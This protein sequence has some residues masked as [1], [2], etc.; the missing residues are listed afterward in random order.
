MIFSFFQ[1][2][3][4][5]LDEETK[6][7]LQ[8]PRQAVPYAIIQLRQ[9]HRTIYR[10]LTTVREKILA[11][12]RNK[13]TRNGDK[14]YKTIVNRRKDDAHPLVPKRERSRRSSDCSDSS[15]DAC[16][17]SH[18]SNKHSKMSKIK[19][20]R[21]RSTSST[22]RSSNKDHEKLTTGDVGSDQSLIQTK[23]LKIEEEIKLKQSKLTELRHRT[24]EKSIEEGEYKQV[25]KLEKNTN[26]ISTED[27][28][29]IL[30]TTNLDNHLDLKITSVYSTSDID[31]F[32]KKEHSSTTKYR[33][34]R[35]GAST[36][37]LDEPGDQQSEQESRLSDSLNCNGNSILD[38]HISVVKENMKKLSDVKDSGDTLIIKGTQE[39]ILHEEIKG[40]END[41]VL[42][43]EESEAHVENLATKDNKIVSGH[44]LAVD[45]D[46]VKMLPI[47]SERSDNDKDI[48]EQIPTDS[49]TVDI[50]KLFREA[51]YKMDPSDLYELLTEK[52]ADSADDVPEDLER[53]DEQTA[54]CV[55]DVKHEHCND[56]MVLDLSCKNRTVDVIDSAVVH[57]NV[58]RRNKVGII[59]NVSPDG[60]VYTKQDEN[61]K[62]YVEE[63]HNHLYIHSLQ[64]G[65]IKD[66][67]CTRTE[68]PRFIAM[69]NLDILASVASERKPA[70]SMV[71]SEIVNVNT[72]TKV[73]IQTDNQGSSIQSPST[74]NQKDT[75]KSVTTIVAN[76]LK[77]KESLLLLTGLGVREKDNIT[78]TSNSLDKTVL[79]V[80]VKKEQ[81]CILGEEKVYPNLKGISSP[82]NHPN[83][84]AAKHIRHETVNPCKSHTT[85]V[86][87]KTDDNSPVVQNEPIEKGLSITNKSRRQSKT[88]TVSSKQV[89]RNTKYTLMQ[90]AQI[91]PVLASTKRKTANSVDAAFSATEQFNLKKN[92]NAYNAPKPK[93]A[94]KQKGKASNVDKV[95]AN[96]LK[97][98]S[99]HSK[100]KVLKSGKVCTTSPETAQ[101]CRESLFEKFATC[102]KEENDCS[103]NKAT[104]C[105]QEQP[106]ANQ[107]VLNNGHD[108]VKMESEQTETGSQSPPASTS[109]HTDVVPNNTDNKASKPCGNETHALD[110]PVV[111]T[112]NRRVTEDMKRSDLNLNTMSVVVKIE[113][114]SPHD[115]HTYDASIPLVTK[116]AYSDVHKSRKS[117]EQTMSVSDIL[118]SKTKERN[119]THTVT[120]P[121][122]VVVKKEPLSPTTCSSSFFSAPSSEMV[123]DTDKRIEQVGQNQIESSSNVVSDETKIESKQITSEI[124]K[125]LKDLEQV[126]EEFSQR[127]RR[128]SESVVPNEH[129]V[130]QTKCSTETVNEHEIKQENI[131]D[132]EN[133]S[134]VV[135]TE[136]QIQSKREDISTNSKS[137]TKEYNQRKSFDEIVLSGI[138]PIEVITGNI[139]TRKAT[140]ANKVSQAITLT[141]HPT[142]N[143]QNK[144]PSNKDKSNNGQQCKRSNMY[145]GM[146]CAKVKPKLITSSGNMLKNNEDDTVIRTT[147]VLNEALHESKPSATGVVKRIKKEPI[148]EDEYF[149]IARSSLFEPLNVK[150]KKKSHKKCLDTVKLQHDD[151]YLEGKVSESTKCSGLS[152]YQDATKVCE[153]SY[154]NNT[155]RKTKIK[156]RQD[157]KTSASSYPCETTKGHS[158]SSKS[159]DN[160]RRKRSSESDKE[161]HDIRRKDTNTKYNHMS[162]SRSTETNRPSIDESPPRDFS[163][164]DKHVFVRK[165]YKYPGYSSQISNKY[166]AV[167]N[168]SWNF[169]NTGLPK[170]STNSFWSPY[171]AKERHTKRYDFAVSNRPHYSRENSYQSNKGIYTSN[172]YKLSTTNKKDTDYESHN[173]SMSNSIRTS[174]NNSYKS[175]SFS[176]ISIKRE[177]SDSLD[178]RPPSDFKRTRSNS[179]DRGKWFNDTRH[180]SD[181]R[182]RTNV[183]Q[184]EHKRQKSDSRDRENV[185]QSERKRQRSDSR[186]RENVRQSERKRQRS[187][188][189]DRKNVRHFDRKRQ[190]SDSRDHDSRFKFKR[191]NSRST[192]RE[193]S[194]SSGYKRRSPQSKSHVGLQQDVGNRFDLNRSYSSEHRDSHSLSDMSNRG[195]YSNTSSSREPDESEI[196]NTLSKAMS[197]LLKKI[198]FD[199][200]VQDDSKEGRMA[201]MVL[202]MVKARVN[203][204]QG[205]DQTARQ[206]YR[207]S[208]SSFERQT[209]YDNTNNIQRS[210]TTPQT[211]RYST[212]NLS[213]SRYSNRMS[214][215]NVNRSTLNSNRPTI[216]NSILRTKYN[217]IYKPSSF[218]TQRRG[219]GSNRPWSRGRF[220]NRNIS[221]RNTNIR[222]ISRG[223]SRYSVRESRPERETEPSST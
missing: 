41:R 115:N 118:H 132:H 168:R 219:I 2:Y 124:D 14:G 18:K 159:N 88:D 154:D 96:D 137:V 202:D 206:Q 110:D 64:S 8:H 155:Q 28:E 150:K 99:T 173:F 25:M 65:S 35:S 84:V 74:N 221:N 72:N 153:S 167:S 70:V 174:Q 55:I 183:K 160:R 45:T 161:G 151:K 104:V 40:K 107:S 148:T 23:L 169:K 204:D 152:S 47:K 9:P 108:Y 140:V 146:P 30:N 79:P 106:R 76:D 73:T 126:I 37:T 194:S 52:L 136:N 58:D 69:D 49:K 125:T 5:Q 50:S 213:R 120:T 220:I 223:N 175:S 33:G 111:D 203:E 22:S 209:P 171:K 80:E 78:I 100:T 46:T 129:S 101:S 66:D 162:Q 53:E 127:V 16:D 17:S 81:A 134:N 139:P 186:D 197:T 59:E 21:K 177:R 222:G 166:Q 54:T 24:Q 51:I 135:S 56:S 122:P 141:R 71:K 67:S 142:Y 15:Q 114:I 117:N 210:Y 216:F 201:D 119:A 149:G 158:S 185:R 61:T 48:P 121:F 97:K 43:K 86:V 11:H 82:T 1:I 26:V 211:T 102:D 94:A 215:H 157:G 195:Q 192:E 109:V 105:V 123:T 95:M 128:S 27:S 63:K 156:N 131:S 176:R 31:N 10:P 91:S 200:K 38:T 20:V 208:A 217:P 68:G 138:R 144:I 98:S 83:T 112:M 62:V 92:N 113:P 178:R 165:E 44:T 93:R 13:A 89:K 182:G 116:D 145:T 60:N 212:G 147:L 85:D 214:Y 19:R 103:S 4:Y 57:S 6:L 133:D 180:R 172:P 190:R 187:Y 196:T 42:K 75:I 218:S 34:H 189:R 170:R 199:D 87:T 163:K 12:V 184:S 32:T 198:I 130:E 77:I 191:E 193:S 39:G 90:D 179:I 207:Q 36:P 29:K 181:S 7:P 164:S 188:S 205:Q 3:I 143:Q